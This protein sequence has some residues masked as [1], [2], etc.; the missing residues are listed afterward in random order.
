[1]NRLAA[2]ALA[3]LALA[4]QTPAA[5]AEFQVIYSFAPPNGGVPQAGLTYDRKHDMFYGTTSATVFK[6]TP[7][8]QVTTLHTFSNDRDGYDLTGGVV[9]DAAGNIFGVATL[10]GTEKKSCVGIGCGTA[11]KIAPDG[12]F[13]LLHT[14]RGEP[15]DGSLPQ[16]NLV[17][18]RHGNLYGTTFEGGANDAGTVF[19]LAPDGTMNIL[20]AF[21]SAD[22]DGPEAGLLPARGGSFY[23]TTERG[24]SSDQGTAFK[25]TRHGTESVL[26]NFTHEG[27]GGDPVSPLIAD[28]DGNLYGT[29][30]VGGT[31]V[32]GGTVFKLSPGST[33]TVLHNF[34]GGANDGAYP[35]SGLYRDAQGNLYGTTSQGGTGNYGI[36]YK[37]APDGTETVLHIFSGGADGAEPYYASLIADKKGRLYGT[38][39]FGGANKAGVI[40]R[41]TP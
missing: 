25:L 20:H 12:T 9:L 19:R 1:M 14:F 11:Y 16:G 27:D 35:M 22:G 21:T 3:A 33:E 15:K 2:L 39:E 5:A 13:S 37:V 6:M 24:G 28:A 10:G 7:D 32:N 4:S 17:L 8:G 34:T 30:A 41:I 38:T 18:D 40:F 26:H 36:V 23:G 31:D 29:T